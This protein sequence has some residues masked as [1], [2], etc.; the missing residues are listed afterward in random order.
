MKMAPHPPSYLALHQT[1]RGLGHFL[2]RGEGGDPA[3]RESRVRGFFRAE[4][5]MRRLGFS[6]AFS[7]WFLTCSVPVCLCGDLLPLD[8]HYYL[9]VQRPTTH[10]VDVEIDLGKVQGPGLDLVM[11]AWAPGRYAIYDFAKNVQEFQATGEQNQTLAWTKV[12]KQTWHVATADPGERVRVRYRVYGNDLTGS[13][14][15]LDASHANLNGASVYMYVNGHKQDPLTLTVEGPSDWKLISGFSESTEQRTFHVPNYDVLIDTPVELSAECTL[16]QFQEHGKTFRIAVHNYPQEQTQSSSAAAL[17]TVNTLD[18]AAGK[19]ELNEGPKPKVALPGG[20]MSKLVEGVKKIVGAEMEM[21]PAPDFQ[22]Y[23]FIFHFAP[24]ISSGDGMEHLNSTEIM[25]RGELSD[26]TLAEALGDAAHEFFH[27]WNVKRL[28]PAVLGPFDYT[29]ENYTPSLWFAEGLTSY[30]TDLAL[31]RSGI[32]SREEF[33]ATLAGEIEG[34]EMEPGRLI[35]SAESSSFNAWFYDRSPQMQQTNFAN[36]TISYYNKGLVL[37]MLLD[38]E[39]RARTVGQK[40]LDDVLRLMYHRF[41]EAAPSSYYGPGRGYEEKD[42][43]EAVNSVSGSDFASFFERYVQGV[44]PLAYNST[45]S[46]AG[47]KLH[48]TTKAGTPPDLGVT[49]DPVATGVRVT[50]IRPGGAADRAGLSRNDL[51]IAVDELSL[52]TEELANRLKMYLPGSEVPF[53][54]ERHGR[55]QR[56]TVKLDPPLANEYSIE[57]LPGATPEQINIRNRWLGKFA[58]S[59]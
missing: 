20:A 45:L 22:S 31:L 33:L 36:T 32:W 48:I 23:T 5:G 41:Y 19:A 30:Y 17:P 38:L 4:G 28:R 44:E 29:R 35:M 53:T 37:G 13:F 40:S 51:L 46:L 59:D 6:L 49:T 50:A 15:Q 16:E 54:V 12:D 57:E 14:S 11:P 56:I 1:V 8:L 24:D 25:V 9:R 52:A 18:V 2:P 10:I 58:T 43:L 34:L 3:K 27:T 55:R 26:S 47:L 21:M 7:F 42:T 39:I